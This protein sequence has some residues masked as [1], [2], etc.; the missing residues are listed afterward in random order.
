MIARAGDC[1]FVSQTDLTARAIQFAQARKYGKGSPASRFNH[2]FFV[3]DDVG[4]IIQANQS[5]VERG[6]LS[7]Y[8][9][10][11]YELKRPPYGP[12]GAQ[13]AVAAA[14]AALGTKYGFL[15]I[16]SVA[17]SLLTGTKLRFGISGE[18][19]CSGAAAD[20]MD[21]ANI[22]C[23]P[24]ETYDTPS[25]LWTLVAWTETLVHKAT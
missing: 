18:E 1:G 20:W 21:R 4:G 11:T 24:D 2:V 3:S 7:Q 17:L 10:Q 25:D 12:G 9:N 15:T 22:D 19:I 14:E 8:A 23:G 6:R 13:I 16:A 5:G